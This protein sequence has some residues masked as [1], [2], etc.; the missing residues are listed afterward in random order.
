M[1]FKIGYEKQVTQGQSINSPGAHPLTVYLLGNDLPNY[2][3]VV[4][5]L[6]LSEPEF[7]FGC[8]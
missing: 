5:D 2:A 1:L 6:W 7:M 4:W 8:V 3:S